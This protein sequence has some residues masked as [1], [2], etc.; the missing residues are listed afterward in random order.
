MPML[1]KSYPNQA[2]ARKQHSIYGFLLLKVLLIWLC[3]FLFQ[4]LLYCNNTRLFHPEGFSEWAGILWDSARMNLAAIFTIFAPYLVLNLL[5]FEFRWNKWYRRIVEFVFYIIPGF[6]ILFSEGADAGYYQYTYRQ[7]SGEIFSYLGVSG[8]YSALIPHFLADFW[9]IFLI[10]FSIIG[11][12]IWQSCKIRL[13][14]RNKH[15][16]HLYNDLA[17]MVIGLVIVFFGAR[18]LGKEWISLDDSYKHCEAKHNTLVKNSFYNVVRTA[19]NME[20]TEFP[21]RE[22]APLSTNAD[23]NA[24]TP[25]TVGSIDIND[26]VYRSH[27][28]NVVVI[29]LESFSQEYMG[30]YNQGI[31]PSFTPFLDSLAAHS[32]V[33]QGRSNGK[34]SIEGLPAIL[35]STP[36]LSYIPYIMDSSHLKHIDAIPAI[37]KKMGYTTAFFHGSYR[38]V[39]GFESFCKHCGFDN[40][41]AEDDFYRAGGAKSDHDGTWGIYDEPYLQYMSKQLSVLPTPF[42]ASVFTLSSHHPYSIPEQYKGHFPKGEHKLMECVA[43]SDNAL[44]KFFDAARRSP[45]YSNTLFIITADHPGQGLHREYNDYDGWYNIPMIVFDPSSDTHFVSER[46]VQQLDIMPSLLDKL[47]CPYSYHACGT[48]VEREPRI[49]WQIVYGNGYFQYV[50]NDPQQPKKHIVTVGRKLE[51]MPI[52]N[53]SYSTQH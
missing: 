43:Y 29:V 4:V 35:A 15:N 50:A 3:M 7:L 42:F 1:K 36:N 46:I 20:V 27:Q 9:Y 52:Q 31:M 32:E 10:G 2:T 25:M 19:L 45:W 48:S 16:K 49:G 6:L 51:D 47:G 13:G 14:E 24:S 18:G 26:S 12:F 33:Y 39:M 8:N 23:T 38:G 17:G 21:Q 28:K 22:F 34:K 40:Y 11:F 44:R 41:Y 30:C 5:P 53:L 37:L